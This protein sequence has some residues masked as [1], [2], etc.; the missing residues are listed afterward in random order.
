[1]NRTFTQRVQTAAVAG[2]YTVLIAAAWLTFAWLMFLAMQS[3]RP[4]W[5]LAL[6]GSVTWDQAR[7]IMTIF[8]S[9]AKLILLTMAMITIWLTLWARKL[10]ALGD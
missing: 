3:W 10:K 5:I 2:W 1:M 4:A 9:V 7:W 6:W 8:I